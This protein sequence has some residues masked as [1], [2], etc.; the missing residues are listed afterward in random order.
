MVGKPLAHLLL[1]QD[2]TVTICHSKT[3]DLAEITRT[4]DILVVAIGQPQMI[5]ADYVKQGAVVID[6]GTNVTAD[7]SLVGDVNSQAM[8]DKA[9]AFSP[10]PGGV[11]PVTTAL[12]LK[13]TIQAA[14]R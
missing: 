9:G 5:S 4:A 13:Q 1:A 14:I 12:L 3:R 7:G 10:V 8:Q 6:V 11:G 2:A